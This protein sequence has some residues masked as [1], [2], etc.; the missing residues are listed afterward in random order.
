MKPKQVQYYIFARE[1]KNRQ[2]QA[3]MLSSTPPPHQPPPTTLPHTAKLP[4]TFK[5]LDWARFVS[6][7]HHGPSHQPS[8]RKCLIA[9][10]EC[11][12][13]QACGCSRSQT[14]NVCSHPTTSPLP[15]TSSPSLRAIWDVWES[16]R[17]GTGWNR[18]DGALTGPCNKND[19][20]VGPP[21]LQTGARAHTGTRRHACSIFASFE[22]IC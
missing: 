16:R 8:P 2:I 12:S 15:P 9:E 18:R 6:F 4:V 5:T 19:R 11:E 1:K 7:L 20:G 3:W 17:R 22:W 21:R 14:D 10:T 13:S